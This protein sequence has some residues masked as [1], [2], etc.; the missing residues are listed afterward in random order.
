M[1]AL[2]NPF[3]DSAPITSNGVDMAIASNPAPGPDAM[4]D[5][6]NDE[7]LPLFLTE[8][9]PMMDRELTAML[10]VIFGVYS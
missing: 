5:P 1:I 7:P 4:A 6:F 3:F 8:P 9:A 10:R 2:P